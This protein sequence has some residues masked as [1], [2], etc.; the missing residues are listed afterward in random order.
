SCR[1]GSLA[2]SG[3]FDAVWAPETIQLFEPASGPPTSDR[4]RF[5]CSTNVCAAASAS[6]LG[7]A[8][9]MRPARLD[10][11]A[12]FGLAEGMVYTL[13]AGLN[14]KKSAKAPTRLP[15]NAAAAAVRAC[16]SE[17]SDGSNDSDADW[18]RPMLKTSEGSQTSKAGLM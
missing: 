16:V 18:K 12:G 2:R 6:R 15:L 3:A 5:C 9:F 8:W 11:V 13:R 7:R 10:A 1:C 14:E 4:S 17:I